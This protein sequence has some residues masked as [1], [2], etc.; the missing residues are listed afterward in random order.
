MLRPLGH[1]A[2]LSPSLLLAAAGQSQTPF[3]GSS[4]ESCAVTTIYPRQSPHIWESIPTQIVSIPITAHY[5][6]STSLF[7][8]TCQSLKVL[9]CRKTQKM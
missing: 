3:I 5:S 7:A 6:L 2:D 1:S 9:I 4:L 8:E